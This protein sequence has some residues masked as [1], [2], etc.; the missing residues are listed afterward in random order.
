MGNSCCVKKEDS[1]VTDLRGSQ[2]ENQKSTNGKK[3]SK[4]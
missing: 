4:A 2:I 3:K 1:D